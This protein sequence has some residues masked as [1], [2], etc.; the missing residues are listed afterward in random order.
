VRMFCYY[1]RLSEAHSIIISC[2][3]PCNLMDLIYPNAKN[4]YIYIY[5][6]IYRERE[7]ERERDIEVS[8][9]VQ[10]ETFDISTQPYR[11]YAMCHVVTTVLY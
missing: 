10:I 4:I 6:Y 2:S 11:R 9:L 8:S 1:V 3:I 7:R 5:I